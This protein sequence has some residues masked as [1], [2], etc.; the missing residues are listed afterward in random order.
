MSLDM[1]LASVHFVW[2]LGAISR[3]KRIPFA[4]DLLT[5]QF[6]PPHSAANLLEAAAALGFVAQRQA[7]AANEIPSLP[8]PCVAVLKPAGDECAGDGAAHS[9]QIQGENKPTHALAIVVK[10]DGESIVMLEPGAASGN[11]ARRRRFRTSSYAGGTDTFWHLP[12]VKAAGRRRCG[13]R[14]QGDPSASP[15]S[16]RSCIKHKRIWR[17]VPAR[18]PRNPTHCACYPL[19]L[20]RSF[21]TK[22][23][24]I[25][26]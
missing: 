19:Y 14:A 5:Q 22:L 3:L 21:W 2:A 8:L 15:G 4:P 11:K 10:A 23:W 13:C 17:D 7:R 24:S 26:P 18:V 20:R 6:P 9:G 16:S 12:V 1:P 25:R